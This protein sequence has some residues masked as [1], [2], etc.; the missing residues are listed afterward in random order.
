MSADNYIDS[1]AQLPPLSRVQSVDD[2]RKVLQEH[3][4]AINGLIQRSNS[5]VISAGAGIQI[6]P[7]QNGTKIQL[8]R[9]TGTLTCEPGGGGT[10]ELFGED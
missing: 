6:V 8:G 1:L 9:V 7:T 3:R 10:V 4:D 2:V 5:Q